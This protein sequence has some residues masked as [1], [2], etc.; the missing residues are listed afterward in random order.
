M[1]VAAHPGLNTTDLATIVAQVYA[2]TGDTVVETAFADLVDAPGVGGAAVIAADSGVV[3]CVLEDGTDPAELAS[4]IAR[5]AAAGWAVV[6]LVPLARLGE[7]HRALRRSPARLQ[8]WWLDPR[9]GI[10]FGAPEVP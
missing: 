8:P 5:L 7:A 9:D 2:A 3:E 1:V 10:C 4:G 6:A